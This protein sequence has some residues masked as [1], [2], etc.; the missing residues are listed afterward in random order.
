M[1]S[2]LP[3]SCF[4]PAADETYLPVRDFLDAFSKTVREVDR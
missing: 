3:I 4:E 2:R 1:L